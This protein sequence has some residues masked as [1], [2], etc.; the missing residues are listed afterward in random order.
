MK[1]ALIVL[2]AILLMV[3][4]CVGYAEDYDFLDNMTLDELKAVLSMLEEL[5]TAVEQ[6]IETLSAPPAATTSPTVTAEQIQYISDRDFFYHS[7]DEMYYIRFALKDKDKNKVA[8][9]CT[10]SVR[11]VNS[12]N[13]TVYTIK[14]KKLTEEDFWTWT[15]NDAKY[16]DR[17][18]LYATIPI[19]KETLVAGSAAEGTMY[20]TVMLEDGSGWKEEAFSIDELPT[21]PVT[22]T[23]AKLPIGVMNGKGNLTKESDITCAIN[24]TDI[25]YEHS[26]SYGWVDVYLSGEV[27][28]APLSSTAECRIA[29]RLKDSEGYVIDSGAFYTDAM[30]YGEKFKDLDFRIFDVK[31]GTY[32]LE[33]QHTSS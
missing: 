10:V 27:I 30:G 33:F 25:K 22:L 5:Q 18:G 14:E 13:K 16:S 12:D 2:V 3:T 24:I 19:S 28:A 31:P 1:R 32:S 9:P 4:A 17:N 23:F 21:L 6:R 29:W 7:G 20:I 15:W 11:L 8:C 26:D